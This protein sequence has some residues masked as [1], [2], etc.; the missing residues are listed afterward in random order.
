MQSH[1]ELEPSLALK[2][3]NGNG[4]EEQQLSIAKGEPSPLER[5][6]LALEGVRA[7]CRRI[8]DSI[9]VRPPIPRVQVAGPQGH[10]SLTSQVPLAAQEQPRPPSRSPY[11]AAGEAAEYLGITVSSLYGVVERGHLMPLRGPR[12]SY[13]FTESM[14]DEYL[15]RRR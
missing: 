1:R 2:G 15:K 4:P 7:E 10:D 6:A 5:I 12:R 13:R 3:R 14:L 11:L 9:E 8:A